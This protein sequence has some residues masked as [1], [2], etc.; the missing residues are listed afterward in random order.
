MV[1][2]RGRGR[3]PGGCAGD[4]GTASGVGAGIIRA[5]ARE[6]GAVRPL[7]HRALQLGPLGSGRRAGHVQPDH[8]GQARRRGGAGQRGLHG[9]AGVERAE[10]RERRRA[11]PDGVEHGPR[12]PHGGERR[13]RVPVHPR[14]RHHPPGCVRPRLL[15]RQDV[16]RLRRRRAGHDGGRRPEELHHDHEGRHRDARRPVRHRAPQGGAVAG[17]GDPH[18][19]RGPG[20]LG[21]DG[22]RPGRSRRCV[23][24]S[25]GALGPPGRPRAVRHRP[26]GGGP[27]QQRHSVAEGA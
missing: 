16:E 3:R 15:R 7:A 2:W 21:R 23:P 10:L 9:V 5:S 13:D 27:R 20:G 25:V 12:H 26:R 19:G 24:H 4:G 22:R 8:A 17:T 18:H 6:P 14:P 11:V 1:D